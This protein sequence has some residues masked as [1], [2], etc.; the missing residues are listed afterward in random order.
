MEKEQGRG[1]KADGRWENKAGKRERTTA[2]RARDGEQGVE[3]MDPRPGPR[4]EG[5][6]RAKRMNHASSAK[7]APVSSLSLSGEKS[8]AARRPSAGSPRWVPLREN[9]CADK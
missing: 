2:G 7:G 6:A 8:K 5:G 3:R 1:E 4:E 9:D